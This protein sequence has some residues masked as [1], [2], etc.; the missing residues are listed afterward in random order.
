M[1]TA[2]GT[3]PGTTCQQATDTLRSTPALTGVTVVSMRHLRS[4]YEAIQPWPIKRPHHVKI[5]GNLTTI[6]DVPLNDPAF[7]RSVEH[8]AIAP[9][10]PDDEPVFI[11]RAKDITGPDAVRGWAE[12]ARAAG[13]DPDLCESV[14]GWADTMA[15]YAAEHYGG[16]KV[17][18]TA[19][20][21]LP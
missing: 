19:P 9:L 2:A 3:R 6:G 11:I 14:E 13:A 16:G 20:E 4:D 12:L 17:P 8:G 15:A 21:L 5:D 10:I 18:D 1:A 7:V